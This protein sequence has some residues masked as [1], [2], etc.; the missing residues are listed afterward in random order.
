MLPFSTTHKRKHLAAHAS[1]L[2]SP[3]TCGKQAHSQFL[4]EKE[5]DST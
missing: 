2:L 1:F 4:P 5:K 3:G